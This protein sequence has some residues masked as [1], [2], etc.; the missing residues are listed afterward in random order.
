MKNGRLVA[1]FGAG[2]TEE[3]VMEAIAG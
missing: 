1:E 2:P 3:M